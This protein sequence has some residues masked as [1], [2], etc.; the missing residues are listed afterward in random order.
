[1]FKKIISFAALSVICVSSAFAAGDKTVAVVNNEAIFE[2]EF[3]AALDPIVKQFKA[4]TPESEQTADNIEK[5]RAYVLDQ[6]IDEMLVKQEVKKQNI[7]VTPKE[8]QDAIDQLKKSQNMTDEDLK[9]ELKKEG[10]TLDKFQSS[11]KDQIAARKVI[12]QGIGDKVNVPSDSDTRAFYDKVM[13][14]VKDPKADTGLSKDDDALASDLARLIKRASAEQAKIR[15]IA[16]NTQGLTGADLKAAQNRVS[17]VRQALKE[18]Q[19]FTLLAGKYNSSDALRAQ[20]GD[21]GA[22]AKGD[23][24]TISAA[25]DEAV[26]K[27]RVG[28]FTKDPIKTN[29]G[30]YFVKVEGKTAPRDAPVTYDEVKTDIQNALLQ[31]A[32]KKAVA[33]YMKQLRDKASITVNR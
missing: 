6:K 29:I 7:K 18:G 24:A 26:F 20:N 14:K 13:M 11:I 31:A 17:E 32:Q 4:T 28:D 3:N 2:S 16:I 5:L 23:L 21:A 33:D 22:I 12:M 9:A 8:V 30:Y 10:L 25:L 1:M 15:V 27:L 19:S